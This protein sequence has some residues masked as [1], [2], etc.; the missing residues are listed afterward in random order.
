[1]EEQELGVR[2]ADILR[3][4]LYANIASC[5]DNEPWNTPVTA[6]TDSDL[7]LYWSSWIHAVHSQ[8]IVANPHV[9]ITFYDSTRA[10]GTN[11]MQC[12]YL[13][14]VVT[15]LCDPVEKHKAHELIYPTE[16]VDLADF[17]GYGLRRFYRAQPLE[18]WLNILSERNL[19]PTTKK[20]RSNVPL[21]CIQRAL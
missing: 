13:R 16:K 18:A 17:S 4:C 5:N 8:N 10:R 6:A 15:V 21:E 3:T 19:Q 2:C 20:M 7:N 9:F 14:C 1:M 12:L 11:N